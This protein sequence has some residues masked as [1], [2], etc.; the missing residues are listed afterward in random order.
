MSIFR[1][2]FFEDVISNLQRGSYKEHATVDEYET[3]AIRMF[4]TN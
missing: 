1:R 3:E 4:S 2:N